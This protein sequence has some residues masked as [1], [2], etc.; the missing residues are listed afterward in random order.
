M[1]GVPKTTPGIDDSLGGLTGLSVWSPHGRDLL[2]G[3]ETKQISKGK[4]GVGRTPREI[5]R[6]FPGS[7]PGGVTQDAMNSPSTEL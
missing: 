6:E 1:S 5:R 4:R 2:Q 7:L 3:K